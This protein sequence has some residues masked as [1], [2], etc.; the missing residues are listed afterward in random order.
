MVALNHT[1]GV[2]GLPQTP[3]RLRRKN[4]ARGSA[5]DPRWV[6]APNPVQEGVWGGAPSNILA[7]KPCRGL[8]SIKP[9]GL[10]RRRVVKFV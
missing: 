5:P 10:V 1:Q 2:G 3:G 9:T 8:D 7:E 6:P 4:V